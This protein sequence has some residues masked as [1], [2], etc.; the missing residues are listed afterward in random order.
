MQPVATTPVRQR[1]T[2]LVIGLVLLAVLTLLAITGMNTASTELIMAGGE[3]YRQNAFQ[4]AETGIER[5]IVVLPTVPQDG[6]PV[7]VAPTLVPNSTTDRFRTTS[8]YMGEDKDVPGF[9]AGKFAGLHYRIES[10]G[11]S[12]RNANALHQQGAYLI[13]SAGG[14][15]STGELPGAPPVE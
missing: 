13:A 12:L 11:T 8:Q 7:V 4:A 5:A 3:Q 10:S 1:G 6:V 14:G 15:E 9:S 2:A